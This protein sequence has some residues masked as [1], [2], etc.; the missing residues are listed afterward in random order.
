[1]ELK[2][3]TQK[4]RVL[5]EKICSEIEQALQPEGGLGNAG[6]LEAEDKATGKAQRTVHFDR[7][8][9]RLWLGF[10]Q[11]KP[12]AYTAYSIS[13]AETAHGVGSQQR[14]RQKI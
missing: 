12:D 9:S 2:K 14:Q 11:R 3:V 7:E 5:D 13:T 1:M 10:H 4:L 8:Q 6:T